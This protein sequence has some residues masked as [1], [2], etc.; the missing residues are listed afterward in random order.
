MTVKRR[1][2]RSKNKAASRLPVNAEK[3]NM[4]NSY[5]SAPEFYYDI[6]FECIDCGKIEVW[7]A[8]Q[9]KWWYE[10]AGGY[11]FATAVRC[12]ACREVERERKRQ[13]RITAG[14]VLPDETSEN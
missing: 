5:D 13:A 7:N 12:N 8:D 10:E 3:L 6:E 2:I 4:G 14:H 1:K 11:F 9:Q